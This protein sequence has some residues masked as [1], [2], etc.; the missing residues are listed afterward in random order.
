MCLSPRQSYTSSSVIS[1]YYRQKIYSYYGCGECAECQHEKS[2]EWLFRAY[3]QFQEVKKAN[4]FALFDTLTYSDDN[5]PYLS[6]FLGAA[7]IDFP[8]FSLPH[9]QEFLNRLRISFRRKYVIP[10]GVDLPLRYFITSEYGTSEKGTHRPHYHIILYC[11][12]PSVSPLDLSYLVSNCWCYGR[13]DGAKFNGKRYVLEKRVI[14]AHSK[15]GDSAH[16]HQYVAKYVEKDSEFSKVVKKRLYSYMFHLY[17]NT[18]QKHDVG[19]DCENPI[20]D[21]DGFPIMSSRKYENDMDFMSWLK[22]PSV[23]SLFI[24]VRHLVE[25]FHKQ[26][27][28]FGAYFL[29]YIDFEYLWRTGCQRFRL[30]NKNA[31]YIDIKLPIYYYRKV[32]QEQ[33]YLGDKLIWQDTEIGKRYKSFRRDMQVQ[34]LANDIENTFKFHNIECPFDSLRLAQYSI[35]YKDTIGHSC[36]ISN[37]DDRLDKKHM[38][39][40]KDDKTLQRYATYYYQSGRIELGIPLSFYFQKQKNCDDMFAGYDDY[41]DKYKQLKIEQK[42]GKQELFEKLQHRKKILKAQYSLF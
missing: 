29:D 13:T 6:D 14:R 33:I 38:F 36:E 15:D 16:L 19:F 35:F 21:A 2:R 34:Y 26:S 7:D 9:V 24:R 17:D 31:T 28:G 11:L 20:V 10:D 42:R 37:V 4:G 8:C 22:M 1:S 25:Q 23:H 18:I 3:W 39:S 32:F 12:L 5:L 41:L 40:Q 27:K 30:P